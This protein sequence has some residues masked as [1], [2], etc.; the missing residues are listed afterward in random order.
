MWDDSL[1]ALTVG[2]S[3]KPEIKMNEKSDSKMKLS[4]GI[5]ELSNVGGC[6][7]F[8]FMFLPDKQVQSLKIGPGESGCKYHESAILLR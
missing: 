4:S 6:N 7:A 1:N 3:G 2:Q 5:V 8:V